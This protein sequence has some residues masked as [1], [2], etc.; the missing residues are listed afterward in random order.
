M[1][2]NL[3]LVVFSV[4]IYGG[5]E[6]QIIEEEFTTSLCKT[7]SFKCEYEDKTV[8]NANINCY[9]DLIMLLNLDIDPDYEALDVKS[10][11]VKAIKSKVRG[12]KFE[13]IFPFPQNIVQE[14]GVT[15]AQPLMVNKRRK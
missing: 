2:R 13:Y 15:L 11:L 10:K 5:K 8:G 12:T 3:V 6:V 1:L 4:V 7:I 9:R 14:L